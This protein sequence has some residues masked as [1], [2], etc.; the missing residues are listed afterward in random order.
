MNVQD[1]NF[2]AIGTSGVGQHCRRKCD[3]SARDA[4]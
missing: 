4:W 2:G 1:S 3:L